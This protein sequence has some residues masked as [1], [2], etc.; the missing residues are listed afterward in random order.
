MREISLKI[1]LD[2]LAV[3]AIMTLTRDVELARLWFYVLNVR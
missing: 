2:I 1:R 3:I